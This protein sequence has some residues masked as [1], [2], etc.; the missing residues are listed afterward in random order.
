VG[1]VT[2]LPRN[3]EEVMYQNSFTLAATLDTDI[4]HS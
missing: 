1:V 2:I 3:R 4:H